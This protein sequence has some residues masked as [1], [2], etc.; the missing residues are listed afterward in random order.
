[1]LTAVIVSCGNMPSGSSCLSGKLSYSHL[2]AFLGWLHLIRRQIKEGSQ[3]VN[4][5][6]WAHG[7]PSQPCVHFFQSPL[8]DFPLHVSKSPRDVDSYFRRLAVQKFGNL[9]LS[10]VIC[11]LPFTGILFIICL[12][13]KIRVLWYILD[14][15]HG[16]WPQVD[17]TYGEKSRCF[18]AIHRDIGSTTADVCLSIF[19][20]VLLEL[21]SRS[22]CINCMGSPCLESTKESLI[23][24]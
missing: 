5:L 15:P 8:C 9:N 6:K 22:S 14:A 10:N 7:A 12:A 11:P 16:P 18:L 3:E 23:K 4:R 13:Q 2:E 19:L 17:I 1:M 21:H 20:L 24:R